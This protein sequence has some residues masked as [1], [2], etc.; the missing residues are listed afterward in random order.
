MTT[1]VKH[2]A[3]EISRLSEAL[4]PAESAAL[5]AQR[6]APRGQPAIGNEPVG[7]ITIHDSLVR[8]AQAGQAN[9]NVPRATAHLINES[10]VRAKQASEHIRSALET[11]ISVLRGEETLLRVAQTQLSALLSNR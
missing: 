4:R 3:R 9:I 7:P 5:S 8:S 1:G 10:L 11:S 6:S 2:L